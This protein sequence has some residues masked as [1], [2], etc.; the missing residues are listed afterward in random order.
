MN[1][2]A[3]VIIIGG[4]IHGTST[5]FH[6]AAR[7]IKTLVLE[8]NTLASAAT[9]RSSG[10]VRM[11]YDL[12][13]ESRLAWESFQYFRDWG[14]RVGGDS[15]TSLSTD[16]GF[17]RTGFIQIVTPGYE[18]QL[19]G[20]V[21]M[22]QQIGIPSL[23]VTRDDVRRLA[24][25]FDFSDIEVAAY[26]PE[27][28]YADPSA[29]TTTLMDAARRGGARLMQGCTVTG[30]QVEAG[31][32]SGVTTLDGDFS[33]PIIINAAGPWAAGVAKMA[34]VDLPIDTWRHDT[35][36]VNRPKQ[37]GASHPTVIDNANS[38]Y[39]RPE[40]GGLTLVGLEDKNPLGQS[41]EGY[42]DRAQPGFVERAIE[43]ICLRVPIMEQASLHSAHGG[44]D[45]ITPDQRAAIGQIGP[46]G[47]FVQC[48]FSGTGF[49]IGPAVGACVAELIV[50]GAAKTVDITPFD[51]QRFERGDLLK[52]EHAYEDIWH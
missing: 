6:L 28:G 24:P 11:H 38:M 9:G 42:T 31:K 26:E 15:S 12:E 39:F 49:K 47:F 2:T 29:T 43:R 22:H 41:P 27:S 37:L 5:A 18:D 30:I 7:G 48:G 4:G 16:C 14:E 45:G 3:D 44:Y 13:P 8:K 46:E 10:L 19:R 25:L 17:T 21:A 50:D 32:V 52:G 33:A 20:N 35:M 51:P 40:T 1:N 36:F 23:L 34:G